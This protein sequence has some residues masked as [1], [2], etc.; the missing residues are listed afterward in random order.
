MRAATRCPLSIAAGLYCL[1]GRASLEQVLRFDRPLILSLGKPDQ[2]V[3][4]LLQGAGRRNVRIDVAGTSIELPRE[5]LA[6]FWSGDFIAIWRVPATI[7]GSLRR[8]DAGPAVAW[9]KQSLSRLDHGA[10]GESGPAY[11]DT[12]LEERVRKLQLA[13]GIQADGII[14]PETL[15]ALSALDQTGPHLTRNIE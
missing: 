9:V 7:A 12:D 8:G 15:F 1:R 6:P 2:P 5:E 10:D 3:H 14:G 13:Y 4:A 11:F